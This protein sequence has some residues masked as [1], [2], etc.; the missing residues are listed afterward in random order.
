MEKRRV[1]ITGMGVVAPNGIGVE[2]FWDLPG[3]QP[4]CNIEVRI[5]LKKTCLVLI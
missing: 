1:V 5:Q 4:L 2:N 3:Y